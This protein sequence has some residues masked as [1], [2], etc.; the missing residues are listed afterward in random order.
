MFVNTIAF[1][2]DISK[3]NVASAMSFVSYIYW[4]CYSIKYRKFMTLII[5]ICHLINCISLFITLQS[6]ISETQVLS[7]P[8]SLNGMLARL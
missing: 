2:S 7:I 8:T 6:F 1:N 4:N 5:H 3:W